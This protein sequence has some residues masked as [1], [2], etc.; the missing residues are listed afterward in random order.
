MILYLVKNSPTRLKIRSDHGESS[1]LCPNN[2]VLSDSWQW[3]F[4]GTR[5]YID[6]QARYKG[7]DELVMVNAGKINEYTIQCKH[8]VVS[9]LGVES[10]LPAGE[11]ASQRAYYGAKAYVD[12]PKYIQWWSLL[13]P[14]TISR[15]RL[16]LGT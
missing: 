11:D 8:G 4:F 9:E 3:A 10:K 13:L 15:S 16:I 5:E 6:G 1:Y 2:P 12:Q 14:I 7:G